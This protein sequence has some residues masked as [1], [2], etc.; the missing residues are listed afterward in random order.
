MGRKAKVNKISIGHKIITVVSEWLLKNAAPKRGYLCDFPQICT[1]VIP[2]DVLLVEGRSRISH[3]IK[4]L[5]QSPWS[6][7]V[8]YIGRISD[9]QDPGL[10]EKI[11]QKYNIDPT[12]Q[13]IIESELGIGTVV[14]PLSKYQQDHLRILR[15]QG[16]SV[17]DSQ[18]IIA[19]AVGRLGAHYNVRHVLELARFLLPWSILPRKWGSYIFDHSVSQPLEDI[20]SSMIAEAFQSI[21]FPVLPIIT[22]DANKPIELIER[23][24]RLFT[25][26][27]FDFS[28]YFSIIKYPIFPVEQNAYYHHLPWKAKMNNT[29]ADN[30]PS[31]AAEL[32]K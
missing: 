26:S 25:P 6:H 14:S 15:P 9:I 13:L 20:C 30:I 27:D 18:S 3:V 31:S 7:A 11:K 24:P 5:T 32:P 12:L 1:K 19:F 28:P 22:M 4:T 16:L 29:T 2:G 10:Q 21:Q 17:E 8:L 23:N